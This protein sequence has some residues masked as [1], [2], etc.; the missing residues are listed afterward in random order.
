[1]KKVVRTVWIGLLSGLAFLV[2]CCTQNKINNNNKENEE[3]MQRIDQLS[4]QLESINSIIQRREGACVYGS[5]EIIEQ[6]GQ[7][8]R[9][10][11][12]EAEQLQQQI[13]ELKNE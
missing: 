10:L 3:K 1:M 8:T 6:Y 12:Q 13:N 7:E 2:G 9:R 11:K 4:H 5:P